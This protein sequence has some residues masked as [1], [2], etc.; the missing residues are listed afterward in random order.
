MEIPPTHVPNRVRK[1]ACASYLG[2][3]RG[4][5]K[6]QLSQRV[7]FYGR[8]FQTESPLF[9]TVSTLVLQVGPPVASRGGAD[10]GRAGRRTAAICLITRRGCHLFL[11]RP[12]PLRGFLRGSKRTQGTPF[13]YVS[14]KRQSKIGRW[15]LTCRTAPVF[16]GVSVRTYERRSV[17]PLNERQVL[18]EDCFGFT[19]WCWERPITAVDRLGRRRVFPTCSAVLR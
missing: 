8:C 2:T 18:L 16:A 4:D 1:S 19:R 17:C 11:R 9:S 12:S 15:R 7:G 13:S 3:K 14:A 10:E 5:R 6:R